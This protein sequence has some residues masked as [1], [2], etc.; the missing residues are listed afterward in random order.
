MLKVTV[1]YISQYKH[2]Q[3][4]VSK[5]KP[6]NFPKCQYKTRIL[7]KKIEKKGSC[8]KARLS[9]TPLSHILEIFFYFIVPK[10]C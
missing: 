8:A 3:K 6:Y 10:E 5:G 9:D 2:K 1:D 7:K 4:K